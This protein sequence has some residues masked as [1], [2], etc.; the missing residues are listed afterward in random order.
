MV[1]FTEKILNSLMIEYRLMQQ[2]DINA[3]LKLCREAQWNQ[4]ERD[5]QIFLQLS[6]EGCCVAVKDGQVAGTV[7]TMCYGHR[8]SWIGMVLV[9]V[10][11]KRQG[12]GSRLLGQALQILHK[13]ETIKLDATSAGREV[14]LKLNFIDEYRLSR[15]T[16]IVDPAK[17]NHSSARHAN[18]N[19]LD[20]I[21]AFDSSIFGA[22]RKS[23][24]QW[25]W[26][27]VPQFFFVVSEQNA[28]HGYCMAR[29]GYNFT[30]IGPIVANDL[31]VAKE[32]LL[33]VLRSCVA[34][35]AVIVDAMHF[36]PEWL[37][38][39]ESIGFSELRPFIRMY[40]GS[41]RF[42]GIPEKQFAILGPEFG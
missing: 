38:F 6:P 12:I 36:D 16:A 17:L 5:W 20:G 9:D 3:G 41:N 2:D 19:D 21:A 8:F 10:A 15:M 33:A 26:E 23:L 13:E 11:S 1:D 28:V 24:L 25:M 29:A 18:K 40:R 14:Y 27:G 4:L 34:G 22:D 7:T 31:S 37:A 35:S 32:L 42:P 39:L 30:H